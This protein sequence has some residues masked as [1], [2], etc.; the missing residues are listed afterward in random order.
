[1]RAGAATISDG[2]APWFDRGELR[3]WAA[4]AI[5]V[6]VGHA[7]AAILANQWREPVPAPDEEPPALMLELAPMAAAPEAVPEET[8]EMV[9]S[10]AAERVEERTEQAEPVPPTPTPGTETSPEEDVAER[11]EGVAEESEKAVTEE[12]AKG[13][14]EVP[15]KAE[16]EKPETSQK[17]VPE[18]AEAETTREQPVEAKAKPQQPQ[19]VVTTELVQAANLEVPVPEQ[20]MEDMTP[21][22]TSEAVLPDVATAVPEPRPETDVAEVVKPVEEEKPAPAKKKAAPK[23]VKKPRAAQAS[24]PSRKSA[25]NSTT[26]SAPKSQGAQGSGVSPARWQSRVNAHLNR[27]KRFPPG[28][29]AK[30]VVTV[31]FTIDRGGSVLGVSVAQSSGDPALDAA[32][33]DMVRRASPVPAPPTAI[34]KSRMSLTVPVRF[35]RR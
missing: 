22:E 33:V 29:S 24:A 4:A 28:S 9:N 34:A 8:V 12:T 3:L 30:G 35:S 1:M 32:A 23:E 5:L 25:A 17:V 15:D 16:P 7:G 13:V 11:V 19:E 6:V 26:A 31:R 18:A 2:P 20:P 10:A 14:V 21:E 27:Y